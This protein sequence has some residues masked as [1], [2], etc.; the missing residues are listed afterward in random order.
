MTYLEVARKASQ[1][2][3]VND[4][5]DKTFNSH[6]NR[7]FVQTSTNQKENTISLCSTINSESD[8][9]DTNMKKSRKGL[10]NEG[11]LLL[12]RNPNERFIGK[13]NSVQEKQDYL[14]PQRHWQKD[15]LK[16]QNNYQTNN[17]VGYS[18][19][20]NAQSVRPKE[21]V[22]AQSVRPKDPTS[23]RNSSKQN[24]VEKPN[25]IREVTCQV[26]STGEDGEVLVEEK[27]VYHD[28]FQ[29]YRSSAYKKKL[30]RLEN[31]KNNKDNKGLRS[32]K[33]KV[34]SRFVITR[35]HP[36]TTEEDVEVELMDTFMDVIDEIYVRKNPMRKHTYYS[37]F[38]VIITTE[39]PIDI[40]MIEDYDWPGEV[41][42]F[43]APN[44]ER[45]RK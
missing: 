41:R 19:P 11:P 39:E 45:F 42:C 23:S 9:E 10:Q 35:A 32:M 20:T 21:P 1:N 7:S 17:F 33:G 25:T 31:L 27:S 38:V 6:A 36:D 43:F 3:Q 24:H 30:K 40:Q 44:N 14:P 15:N 2:K 18:K 29:V 34:K 5:K 12:S 22:N 4:V 37:T 28:G 26:S 13:E 16:N 8:W